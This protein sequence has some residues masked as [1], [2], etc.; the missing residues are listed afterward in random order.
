LVAALVKLGDAAGLG[1][2]LTCAA[3]DL[4]IK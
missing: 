4:E 1:A 2:E 3:V